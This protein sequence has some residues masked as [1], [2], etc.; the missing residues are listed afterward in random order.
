MAPEGWKGIYDFS[1]GNPPGPHFS[2]I[3]D[4]RT[5]AAEFIVRGFQGW[6]DSNGCGTLDLVGVSVHQAG[7]ES[8]GF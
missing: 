3:S 8:F 2:L 1:P 4:V 6:L 7:N 5:A